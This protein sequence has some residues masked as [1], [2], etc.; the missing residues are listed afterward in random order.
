MLCIG[1]PEQLG[2]GELMGWPLGP[3]GFRIYIYLSRVAQ[4][5]EVASCVLLRCPANAVPPKSLLLPRSLWPLV[6]IP[7]RAGPGPLP[8]ISIGSHCCRVPACLHW[9]QPLPEAGFSP[10]GSEHPLNSAGAHQIPSSIPKM[11]FSSLVL[12]SFSIFLL[13]APYVFDLSSKQEF[14]P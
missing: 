12:Q 7:A 6:H 8:Q 14:V 9:V 11:S 10:A 3:L 1:L 5:Q 13:Y 2:F 4:E